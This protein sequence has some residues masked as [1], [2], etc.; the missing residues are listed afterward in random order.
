[1]GEQ[2]HAAVSPEEVLTE[3]QAIL[4]GEAWMSGCTECAD[5]HRQLGAI[6]WGEQASASE[7]L[8]LAKGVLSLSEHLSE[9]CGIFN[10]EYDLWLLKDTVLL[11]VVGVSST[12]AWGPGH[13]PG[14][15][16]DNW[17]DCYS[18]RE[19]VGQR[20]WARQVLDQAGIDADGLLGADDKPT[21]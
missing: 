2:N 18:C 6:V 3:A 13:G 8:E 10:C 16:P 7:A 17:E 4:G 11:G 19:W 14:T 1:M 15:H 5:L 20:K 9:P 12:M 21:W